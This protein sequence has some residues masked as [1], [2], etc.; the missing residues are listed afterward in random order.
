MFHLL[1][2]IE[3]HEVYDTSL[4]KTSK[5]PDHPSLEY[6]PLQTQVEASDDLAAAVKKDNTAP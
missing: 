4:L 2:H 3:N 1:V 6:G 5:L